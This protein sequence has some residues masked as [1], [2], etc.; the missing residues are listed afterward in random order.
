MLVA[1]TLYRDYLVSSW[2]EYSPSFWD[3]ALYAGMFGVFL[4]L[5]LLF[6][7]FLPA[8]SAFELKE[9]LFEEKEKNGA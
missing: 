7:R 1:S 8:I 9:A 3:W 5:F 4:T 6:I 2:R